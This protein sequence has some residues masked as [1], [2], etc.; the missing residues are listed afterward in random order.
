MDMPRLGS[1]NL[2]VRLLPVGPIN[3]AFGATRRA[4]LLQNI[5]LCAVVDEI[6]QF[7]VQ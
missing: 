1:F 5:I 4:V 2:I 6:I 3:V 7:D